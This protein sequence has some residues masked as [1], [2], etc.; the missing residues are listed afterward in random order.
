MTDT[1]SM[2]Y[3][4]RQKVQVCAFYGDS[5][6]CSAENHSEPHGYETPNR[7]IRSWAHMKCVTQNIML[8]LVEMIN[9][10]ITRHVVMEREHFIF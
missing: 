10:P 7:A 1:W 4:V 6:L 9:S 5:A 2:K 8:R 3:G